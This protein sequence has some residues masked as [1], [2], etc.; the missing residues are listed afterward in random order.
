M[1]ESLQIKA[2]FYTNNNDIV[3]VEV[4]GYI[5]QTNSRQIEK[6]ISDILRSGKKKIVFD[7]ADLIYMSSAGWGIFVGE[8]KTVRDQGGD[9][10]LT[11]MTPEVYEV[12]QML[13]FFHII[14][15]YPTI[16][17]AVQA[18]LK[19]SD[20]TSDSERL[21]EVEENDSIINLLENSGVGAPNV[22]E[23]EDNVEF[24]QAVQKSTFH[25][26]ELNLQTGHKTDQQYKSEE[27]TKQIDIAQL[28]VME[29]IK[30]VVANYPLLNIFQIQRMLKHEKF[31]YT[32]M[33]ILHLHSLLKK[34]NLETKAKRY[35]YYRSV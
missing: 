10:K 22:K 8:I 3:I 16:D 18:F 25:K 20:M 12:F 26:D 30:K 32:K 27:S 1:V 17:E 21:E 4:G 19:E 28:P 7:L 31:G 6:V 33:N 24:G 29:K 11:S 15:D 34:L 13:E 23:N 14:Q 2:N 35:R 9:I 5:D